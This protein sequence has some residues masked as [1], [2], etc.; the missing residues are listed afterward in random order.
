MFRNTKNSLYF[1]RF[2][3]REM[4]NSQYLKFMT[5][6]YHVKKLYFTHTAHFLKT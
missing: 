2:D 4:M 6:T 5:Y 3:F 1:V